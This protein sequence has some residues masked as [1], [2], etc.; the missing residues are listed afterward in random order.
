MVQIKSKLQ[1]KLINLNDSRLDI[2]KN[3]KILSKSLSTN[4]LSTTTKH[5]CS[6]SC[7]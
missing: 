4:L 3:N 2:F 1:L 7:H 5:Y 6:P